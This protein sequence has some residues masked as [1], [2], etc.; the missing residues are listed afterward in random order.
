MEAL[1]T[2]HAM[3]SFVLIGENIE[4]SVDLS[5]G[6]SCLKTWKK[7]IQTFT[8]Q[9]VE[10]VA[11]QDILGPYIC[12]LNQVCTNVGK[13]TIFGLKILAKSVELRYSIFICC[14]IL[15]ECYKD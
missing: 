4:K 5:R 7:T 11:Y 15:Q 12:G 6:I 1:T 2:L 14:I 13:I 9:L 3:S 8:E 10:F